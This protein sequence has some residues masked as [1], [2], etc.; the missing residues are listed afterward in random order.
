VQFISNGAPDGNLVVSNLVVN[1]GGTSLTFTLTI[2]A[3]ATLG[4]RVVVITTP[5][6][7]STTLGNSSNMLEVIP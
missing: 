7:K 5:D 4:Q 6:G 3:I 1:G 2:N